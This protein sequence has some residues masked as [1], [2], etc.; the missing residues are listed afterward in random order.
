M[1]SNLRLLIIN[2]SGGRIFDMLNL[3]SRIVLPHENDFKS[4]C[5]GFNLTYA[6]DLKSW[7]K[8]QVIELKT[9]LPASRT[10]I[11]EWNQ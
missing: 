8:A 11:K 3:D 5:E 10:F 2:N 1:P 6:E 7:E 9:D 4:I